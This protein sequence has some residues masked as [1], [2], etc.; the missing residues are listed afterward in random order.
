MNRSAW[1]TPWLIA[2][3]APAPAPADNPAR[4]AANPGRPPYPYARKAATLAPAPAPVRAPADP[5]VRRAQAPPPEAPVPSPTIGVPSVGGTSL[6]L[7][8]ALY[9]TVTSNPD[10]VAL[11]QGAAATAEAVEVARQFP[12]TLNPTLWFDIRPLVYERVPKTTLGNGGIIPP[13]LDQKDAL[14]YFSL[15]QPLELGH[16]TTHRYGIA[17]A[18]YDQQRWNVVQAELSA[19]VQTYRSFQTAAYRRER[20]RVAEDLAAFN[21]KLVGSLRARLQ[22]NQTQPADV[23]LAE[24]ED[25]ATRQLAEAARQDYTVALADL[26][27]QIGQ[28][29]GAGLS[30]PLG[31]FALP[32]YIPEVQEDALVPLAL[33]SRPEIHAAQAAVRGA[34][35]AIRL[36]KGDRIPTPV[37]GP[38]YER[39]E[40]GTQ[41]FGFVY[42]T[43]LPVFNSGAP[44]VRQR[45][46]EARR[47]TVALEQLQRRTVAQVKSAVARWNGANRL[48]ARTSGLTDTLKGQVGGLERLFQEGQADLTKLLQARQR[49]IQ[50]ETARLDAIFAATQ[51]QADLLTALGAPT[52][53]ASIQ[54]TA[55]QAPAAR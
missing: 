48:V 40:Q 49:L 24:V 22:A 33:R 44:L 12:T 3:L 43:P 50:L 35:A 5:V 47:A 53:I 32:G 25:E 39:D 54:P 37:V 7:E 17:K 4:P 55:A 20:L 38:T 30:E 36:A 46:A 15:R 28:P 21:T 41:F 29:D 42:I 11:R 23:A 19:L 26:G 52:L 16:Q 8:A 9:G 45:E 13:K 6:S 34:Q 10:L 14:M 1:S 51:A 31:E 18:A 27:N 2:L